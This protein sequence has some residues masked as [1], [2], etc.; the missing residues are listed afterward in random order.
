M[1][2]GPF[3]NLPPAY[4]LSPP[5]VDRPKRIGMSW[6]S[7]S[8]S[9]RDRLKRASDG[10]RACAGRLGKPAPPLSGAVKGPCAF[11]DVSRTRLGGEG[12]GGTSLVAGSSRPTWGGPLAVSVRRMRA[13]IV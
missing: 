3:W 9:S 12:E 4:T 11:H 7:S 2:S 1:G 8:V 5:R 6:G 10:E 13:G